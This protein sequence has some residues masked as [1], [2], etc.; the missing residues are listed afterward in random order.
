[1]NPPLEPL[2]L[3]R[4]QERF[5]QSPAISALGLKVVSLDYEGKELKVRMPFQPAMERR[6]GT[7]QFHGGPIAAFIDI[8]GDYVVGMMLGAPVPTI[9]LRIDYLRPAFG[10]ALTAVARVRSG[11][12]TVSVVDIEVFN[13]ESTLVA[14]GRGTY[15]SKT[16]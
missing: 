7:R 6:P 16:G 8:V 14:I 3:D 15:A 4:I 13:E 5:D 9:N 11:G 10:D 12:R 2:T 1:M